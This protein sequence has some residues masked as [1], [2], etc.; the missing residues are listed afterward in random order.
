M[1]GTG[2]T[3]H[4]VSIWCSIY[5]CHAEYNE[6]LSNNSPAT[7]IQQDIMVMQGGPQ[8]VEPIQCSLMVTILIQIH[9]NSGNMFRNRWKNIYQ[10][11]NNIS[12]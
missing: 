4:P 11:M 1:S 6:M 2:V 5:S 3:E 9:G 12:I 8:K 10:N 7:I